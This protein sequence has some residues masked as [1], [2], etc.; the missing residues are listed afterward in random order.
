M[1]TIIK[2]ALIIY[3]GLLGLSTIGAL[4]ICLDD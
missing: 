2:N 1:I 4:F 3:I